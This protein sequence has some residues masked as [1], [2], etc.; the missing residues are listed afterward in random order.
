MV[1]IEDEGGT[2]VRGGVDAVTAEGAHV[3]LR[4]TPPFRAGDQVELR[5]CLERGQPTFAARA[6]ICWLRPGELAVECGLEWGAG[7]ED[8]A[9]LDAWLASAA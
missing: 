4:E 2:I 6:R 1:W 8:R 5:I 3:R 9:A 7:H